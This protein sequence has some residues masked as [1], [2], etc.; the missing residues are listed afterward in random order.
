MSSD[1]EKPL[2]RGE[3]T[4]IRAEI[5]RREKEL[6]EKAKRIENLERELLA[7]QALAPSLKDLESRLHNLSIMESRIGQLEESFRTRRTTRSS[8]STSSEEGNQMQ[9]TIGSRDALNLI[10]DFDGYNIPVTQFIE[11]VEQVRSM[12]P[13][14]AETNLIYIIRGK[15][16]GLASKAVA[17][18]RFADFESVLTTLR[19]CFGGPKQ[20]MDYYGELIK[21]CMKPNENLIEYVSRTREIVDA[22]EEGERADRGVLPGVEKKRIE[23]KA[24]H[25]FIT[26]LPDDLQMRVKHETFRDL[27]DLLSKAIDVGNIFEEEK[28]RKSDMIKCLGPSKETKK[29]SPN[30]TPKTNNNSEAATSQPPKETCKYCK[31]PGHKIS[32]CRKLAYRRS[33][34]NQGNYLGAPKQGDATRSAPST[35][36]PTMTIQA[37][38]TPPQ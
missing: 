37:T 30:P 2:T 8:E 11:R 18:S 36:R 27:D 13:R 35:S 1:Q 34:Q 28:Q 5:A 9:L 32:E 14:E 16:R 6:E 23:T 33:Q 10:P 3:L 26:G 22:I 19:Q 24:I 15:L 20:A 29:S 12:F 38:P 31:K 7:G 25:K 4:E 17:S 21:L